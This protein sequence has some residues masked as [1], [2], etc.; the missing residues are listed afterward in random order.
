MAHACRF[1]GCGTFLKQS[2]AATVSDQNLMRPCPVESKVFLDLMH[3]VLGKSLNLGGTTFNLAHSDTPVVPHLVILS[4]VRLLCTEKSRLE[5]YNALQADR[6]E[7][8]YLTFSV[9]D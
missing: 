9:R 3:I 4:C 5:T 2:G 8:V 6:C 1:W 7:I